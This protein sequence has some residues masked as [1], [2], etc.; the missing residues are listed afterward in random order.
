MYCRP[1]CFLA[2]LLFLLPA[3]IGA[4]QFPDPVAV[5][6][7]ELLRTV[8]VESK[9][10][11]DF[12]QQP[13]SVTM[14][15]LLPPGYAAATDKRYPVRYNVAGYGGRYSRVNRLLRD[16]AFMD[17]YTS[18][19]APEIITVFLD[20][21]GPFGD[22][23][24]LNSESSGP[25][26]DVLMEEIIPAIDAQFRTA[27]TEERYTDGCSTGGWVS[28]ALQLYYPDTFA[29]CYSYSPDPVSFQ[30][31][32]LIDMY[33][34]SSAFVNSRGLL[35]PSSRD[36]Y[37]EPTLLIRDEVAEE[38]EKAPTGSYVT[39]QG[40]WGAWN[41][42]YS[43]R[44]ADGIPVAAFDPVTGV[45]DHEAVEHWKPYDLLLLVQDN[46]PELGPKLEGKL[47]IWMGDMD[48]YYLNNALRDFDAYLRSVTD[49]PSDAKIEFAP[50]KGHC[51]AYS[52]RVVLE[53]IG[54][55]G[56]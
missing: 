50:M 8:T 56:D 43:P 9:L 47:H 32:Q 7:H 13:V 36:V 23:Y 44:G 48:N 24:Q 42:L 27:G 17:W 41:A 38:N 28:L 37:G 54:K 53:R 16:T 4:Q 51:D 39:S 45:I 25:Y 34:D 22:S 30:R 3:G 19:E 6:Q 12:W 21:S 40:Q 26:G 18:E 20:G 2:F 31:M 46:W 10:L 29:A 5:D 55:R 15:V 35:R 14:A 33:G 49:P 52:H 11:T 1:F